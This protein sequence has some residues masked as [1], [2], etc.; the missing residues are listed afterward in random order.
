M[1]KFNNTLRSLTEAEIFRKPILDLKIARTKVD[2]PD[3]KEV[4]QAMEDSRQGRLPKWTLTD[5]GRLCLALG[6]KKGNRGD[7]W[8]V[9]IWNDQCLTWGFHEATREGK[10]TGIWVGTSGELLTRVLGDCS[11]QQEIKLRLVV[12]KLRRMQEHLAFFLADYEPYKMYLR[13]VYKKAPT[14]RKESER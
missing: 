12:E 1:V 11:T 13:G 7:S 3:S 4:I 14:E 2:F 5:Q 9:A 6:H 10:S 8:K